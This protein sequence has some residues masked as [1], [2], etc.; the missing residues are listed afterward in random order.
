MEKKPELGQKVRYVRVNSEGVVESGEGFVQAILIGVEKRTNIQVKDGDNAFNLEPMAINPND[1]EERAFTA[2]VK[3]IR[4]MA[5][6]FNKRAQ[7]VV[8]EGNTA[9]LNLNTEF[10]GPPIQQ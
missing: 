7:D 1:D 8:L 6:D 10:F 9:I 2:H 3:K 5:D 4:G